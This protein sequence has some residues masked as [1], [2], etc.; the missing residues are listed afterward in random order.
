MASQP[1]YP[2]QYPY[3]NYGDYTNYNYN[4]NT[5]SPP[6]YGPSNYYGN[7][8]SNNPIVILKNGVV[9]KPNEIRSISYTSNEIQF[10]NQ[11]TVILNDGRYITPDQIAMTMTDYT[12]NYSA[13][14]SLETDPVVQYRVTKYIRY[15]FLD[16]WIPKYFENLLMLLSVDSKGN[17]KVLSKDDSGKND[18]SKDTER[19]IENKIDFIGDRILTFTKCYKI[20]K[21]FSSRNNILFYELTKRLL[22]PHVRKQL[23]KYVSKKLKSMR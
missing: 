13:Q 18:I 5:Y 9:I 2:S 15:K 17:V 16:R 8:Q 19:D 10:N 22:Q 23:G 12:N 20:L 1:L 14:S 21:K 4:N 3:Q 7:T 6:N 11:P